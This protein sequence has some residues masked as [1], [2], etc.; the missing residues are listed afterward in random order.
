MK[1]IFPKYVG[2]WKRKVHNKKKAS[3]NKNEEGTVREKKFKITFAGIQ[4]VRKKI[5][6]F[7]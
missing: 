2:A 4:N 7:N 3:Y 1:K 6:E 5:R